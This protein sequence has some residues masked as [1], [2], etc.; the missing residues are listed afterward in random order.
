MFL[1]L[2]IYVLAVMRLTRLINADTILDSP[3]IAIARAFG[4]GSKIVEFFNCP[5]CVGFWLSLG[6]AFAPVAYLGWPWWAALP[7]G[8]ACSQIVGMAAP[9]YADDEIEFEP[10]TE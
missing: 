9:L 2:G 1:V 5:W 10:V 8:L 3:R 7:L 4:P 6:G